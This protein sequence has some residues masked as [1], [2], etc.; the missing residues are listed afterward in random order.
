[1]PECNRCG[2]CCF[3]PTGELKNGKEEFRK[4]RFLIR[5]SGGIYSC[6]IYQNENRLNTLVGT[7]N[8]GKKYR[9][10]K[11]SALPYEIEGCPLNE[12]K[13]PLIKI[14]IT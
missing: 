3:Y 5:H 10:Q 14:K 2:K 4:C 13:K 12:N 1:M 6:R 8:E 7:D 9:C 11:Y